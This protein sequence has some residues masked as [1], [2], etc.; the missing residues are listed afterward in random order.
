MYEHDDILKS[1]ELDRD[2]GPVGE[3]DRRA[4]IEGE[5]MAEDEHVAG[6]GGGPGP[7]LRRRELGREL[8]RL[9]TEAGWSVARAAKYAGFTEVTVR[10]I[11]TGSQTILPRNVRVLCQAYE[12]DAVLVEH[13]MRRAE[14]S[15]ERG[16][17]TAYSA[18]MPDWFAKFV[19]L[20]S[21]ADELRN[22]SLVY[23]DGL[24]QTP[25]YAEA[26][27]SLRPDDAGDTVGRAVELR[28]ARQQR[29]LQDDNPPS[30]HVVLDEAALRRHVGGVEVMREQLRHLVAMAERPNIT[31]QVV[32]FE[33]GAYAGA[34]NL[35]SMLRFP[36]GAD[37]VD[38]VYVENQRG[39]VW[40][41]RP[42]DIRYYTAVFEQ[43]T[44][45]AHTPA[46]SVDF[47]ASLAASL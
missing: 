23:V 32:P 13:L 7:N 1:R 9:R 39:A 8:R 30:L 38:V 33:A 35:F 6:I 40:M 34:Q 21:D 14:E 26:F 37:E 24:L 19:G 46:R 36:D 41:E 29:L 2:R 11:E 28:Q 22:Y 3:D 20:E 31:L 4:D 45:V 44:K 27:L 25:E 47:V 43:M 12:V 16:W 5:P 17:W 15:N 42:A 10:R 18:T